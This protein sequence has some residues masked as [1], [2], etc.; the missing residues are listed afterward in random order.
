MKISSFVAVVGMLAGAAAPALS[1][2]SGVDDELLKMQHEA[3]L[4]SGEK[5]LIAYHH[6]KIT[7]YRVCI[8]EQPGDIRL[9][10]FHDGEITEVLDGTCET[11]SGRHI[12]VMAGSRIP[13][14]D[15]LVLKFGRAKAA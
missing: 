2:S 14:G 1:S 12:D 4:Q 9:E 10:V 13:A 15:D 6:N 7:N 8:P 3:E 5:L 11:V